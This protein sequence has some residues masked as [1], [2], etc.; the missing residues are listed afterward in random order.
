MAMAMSEKE[1]QKEQKQQAGKEDV[2]DALED[3]AEFGNVAA[4]QRNGR[5]LADVFDGAVPG[6]AVVHVGN[7]AQVDAVHARLLED[8]L[9][10]AALAGGGEEDLVDKL[11][12]RMLEERVE[13]A[14]HIAA[15]GHDVRK[16]RRE[17]R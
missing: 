4:V 3:E 17:I 6:Q 15:G 2:E 16:T 10:D 8:I 11:L 14:D 13:R 12:A 9:D 1:G 7:H 5:E